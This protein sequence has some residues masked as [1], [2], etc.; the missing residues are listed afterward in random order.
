VATV[1]CFVQVIMVRNLRGRRVMFIE[2]IWGENASQRLRGCFLLA[3]AKSGKVGPL[4]P[5]L[6]R[7]E[8]N[9]F[10]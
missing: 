8:G 7:M 2:E 10:C 3:V 5:N 9:L 6:S 1:D 4:V